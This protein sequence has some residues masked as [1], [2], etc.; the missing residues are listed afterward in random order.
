RRIGWATLRR[1]RTSEMGAYSAVVPARL[2]HRRAV[3]LRALPHGAAGGA[4]YLHGLLIDGL[5]GSRSPASANRSIELRLLQHLGQVQRPDLAA[6]AAQAA[7]NVHQAAGVG[8]NNHVGAAALDEGCLV[9]YHRATNTR[10]THCEGAAE[11]AALI[12]AL[13]GHKLQA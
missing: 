13:Q 3:S 11:A 12:A 4:V 6:A 8:G 1:S 7:A 9:L 5:I 2:P 10:E